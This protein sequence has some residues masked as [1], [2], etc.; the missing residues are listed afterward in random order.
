MVVGAGVDETFIV[1]NGD[2]L[3]DLDYSWLVRKHRGFG[4]EATLHLVPVDDPS[5]FGVV[6]T[7]E[8]GRVLEFVE[9]PERGT[10]P[11]NFIN[12]GTYVMEPSVLDRI[13][14][15]RKVSV[16]REVFPALAAAGTLYAVG[17]DDYWLDAGTPAALLAANLDLIDGH[18]STIETAINATAKLED[19]CVVTHSVIG[20]RVAISSD[21]RILDSVLMNDVSVGPGAIVEGSIVAA[22]ASI[23]AGAVVVNH[24][25]VG[26]GGVVADGA[27]LDAETEPPPSAWQV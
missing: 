21:A 26:F 11:T 6:P 9:K 18:R 3:T 8:T 20:E 7:D 23:G 5:R 15:D 4:A 13:A 16:E 17:T 24:S 2:V 27:R 1:V 14:P 12:A 25:V 10:E 22:G 19:G